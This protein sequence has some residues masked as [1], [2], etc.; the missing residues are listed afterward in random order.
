M[1]RALASSI[2]L[3]RA[4]AMAAV[5][6]SMLKDTP[7]T[8]LAPALSAAESTSPTLGIS[9]AMKVTVLLTT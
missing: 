5:G 7:L 2:A 9:R 8:V 3:T 4:S 1:A 6:S